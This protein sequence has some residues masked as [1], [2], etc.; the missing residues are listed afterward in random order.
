[1]DKSRKEESRV[2]EGR[3]IVFGIV[4]WTLRVFA[5]RTRGVDCGGMVFSESESISPQFPQ[6][7]QFP[8]IVEIVEIVEFRLTLGIVGSE[9]S[10]NSEI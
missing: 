5:R 4:I 9:W 1:M 2:A 3:C 10:P 8:E 6:F 7:P